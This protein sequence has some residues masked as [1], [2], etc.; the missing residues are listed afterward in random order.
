MAEQ[1]T[2]VPS[3]QAP[4]DQSQVKNESQKQEQDPNVEAFKEGIASL[5][6]PHLESCSNDLNSVFAAQEKI[7]TELKRMEAAI[8]KLS[9][10]KNIPKLTQYCDRVK[11]CRKRVTNLASL[12]STIQGRI[13]KFE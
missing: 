10:F 1:P 8:A 4:Q 11:V 7:L 9:Q 6:I 12:L 2:A 5:I 13:V 3:Q